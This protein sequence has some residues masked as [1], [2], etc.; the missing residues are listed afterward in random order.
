MMLFVLAHYGLEVITCPDSYS[1][2]ERQWYTS[3]MVYSFIVC[4]L[5]SVIDDSGSSNPRIVVLTEE[6]ARRLVDNLMKVSSWWV[7]LDQTVLAWK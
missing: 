4:V 5:I 2:S 6:A 3:I 1:M 7:R